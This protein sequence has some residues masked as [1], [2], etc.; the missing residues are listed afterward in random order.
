MLNALCTPQEPFSRIKRD[1]LREIKALTPGMMSVGL[2]SPGWGSDWLSSL[3][4]ALR[5]YASA[6]EQ[7]GSTLLSAISTPLLCCWPHLRHQSKS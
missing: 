2:Q 5:H 3:A 6:A 7:Y 1:L 4:A